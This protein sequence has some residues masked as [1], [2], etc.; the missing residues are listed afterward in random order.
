MNYWNRR[1]TRASVASPR[2]VVTSDHP[3]R[4]AGARRGEGRASVGGTRAANDG[5]T[6]TTSMSRAPISR[7]GDVGASLWAVLYGVTLEFLTKRQ[8]R[9]SWVTGL[10]DFCMWSLVQSESSFGWLA[11][12]QFFPFSSAGCALRRSIC[13]YAT[14]P[15]ASW[16]GLIWFG[17]K[18]FFRNGLRHWRVCPGLRLGNDFSFE[19]SP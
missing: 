7:S 17:R 4:R 2:R 5:G 13:G 8:W 6:K 16:S 19:I 3:G 12:H 18:R 1:P 11:W 10:T 14:C 15:F 9:A